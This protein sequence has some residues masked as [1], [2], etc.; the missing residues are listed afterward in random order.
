MSTKF[1]DAHI[2]VFCKAPVAGAVKTRLIPEIGS[3]PAAA[4]HA[5]LAT[6]I[7]RVCQESGLAEVALWCDPDCDHAFFKRVAQQ[8]TALHKQQ[9]ADLGERMAFAFRQCLGDEDVQRAILVGTDCPG[10]DATYI[11]DALARLA[12]HDAVIGPAL[13]GGYG[14]IGLREAN[15]ELFRGPAWGSDTVCATTCRLF[16]E[17]GMHWALL[18]M[19]WDVDRPEDVERYRREF[20]SA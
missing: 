18:P 12:D 6:R 8:D 17:C 16:N 4:L 3:G 19:L 9:G 2:L 7:I 20:Q 14:L 10:I 5:E 13:D 15:D 11:E 1:P